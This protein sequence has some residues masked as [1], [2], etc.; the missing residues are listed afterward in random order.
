M[1][2]FDNCI[3]NSNSTSEYIEPSTYDKTTGDTVINHDD[4]RSSISTHA[5]DDRNIQEDGKRT[6]VN[7]RFFSVTENGKRTTSTEHFYNQTANF[8]SPYISVIV[9]VYN[10]SPY[11][12][13]CVNS[14]LNQSYK[15]FEIILVDDGSTD[16][17]G[18]ICDEFAKDNPNI[19]VFHKQNGGLSSARNYGIERAKGDFLTFVDSDDLLPTDALKWLVFAQKIHNSGLVIARL[20]YDLEYRV[21]TLTEKNFRRLSAEKTLKYIFKRGGLVSACS[22]LYDKKLFDQIRF[23]IGYN[24]EDYAVTPKIIGKAEKITLID[25]PLYLYRQN[26]N[27]ITRCQFN[28]SYLK[29][30]EVAEDVKKYLAESFPKLRNITAVHNVDFATICYIKF[31]RAL[32]TKNGNAVAQRHEESISEKPKKLTDCN[33]QRVKTFLVKYVRKHVFRYL[34]KPRCSARRRLFALITAISPKLSEKLA[35]KIQRKTF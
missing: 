23:P 33:D 16:D 27:S 2:D 13:D 19:S 18:I 10:T 26:Q 15:N 14:I 17:S 24:Y 8:V 32:A 7:E 6:T 34:F 28:R 35:V 20:T 3:S 12:S 4:C 21:P 11:L 30:F 5:F 22:K 9:P 25:R 29:F 31:C 1:D